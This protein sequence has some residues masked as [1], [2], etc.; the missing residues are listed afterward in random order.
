MTRPLCPCPAPHCHSHR[1]HV[2]LWLTSR[3]HGSGVILQTVALSLRLQGESQASWKAALMSEA[4]SRGG[5]SLL[6]QGESQA[7]WKA[8]LMSGAESRGGS[9]CGCRGSHR[10]AGRQ[11]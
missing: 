4:E 2:E 8:A 7:S 3:V 6:L 11:P 1:G 5:L 9:A 10:P